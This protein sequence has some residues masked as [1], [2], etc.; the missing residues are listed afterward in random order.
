MD[1][2]KIEEPEDEEDDEEEEVKKGK[3]V[4]L[5]TGKAKKA[6]EKPS[7]FKKGKWNPNVEIVEHCH[8]LESA[9][10]VPNF[11][12]STRNSNREVIR[13]AQIGSEKLMEKIVKSESKISRL[14]ERWG[15]D[16][17]I[18]ALKVLLDKGNKH[19]LMNYLE[20]VTDEK[21]AT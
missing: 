12:C 8:Q 20:L 10:L 14:T 7:V 21:P 19:L 1:E 6:S 17:R 16:N 4:K 9:S 18:T 5:N 11:D 13:A 15:V 2:E 3:K